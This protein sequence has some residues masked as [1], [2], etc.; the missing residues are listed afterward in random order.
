[1]M[2][3]LR[4]GIIAG[5]H[6]AIAAAQQIAS[7]I[8]STMRSAMQIQSPSR[9]MEG[10][11]EYIP[12][13]LAVGME[14]GI[15]DVQ[16]ATT[17]MAGAVTGDSFSKSMQTFNGPASAAPGQTI[18]GGGIT[19]APQITITGNASQGDVQNALQWSMAEF[20][21]MYERMMADDRRTAFA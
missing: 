9:V 11:G 19:F 2:Q 14:N 1:M 12:A 18:N 15:P 13:G 17:N 5:G 20:R 3:G 6:A 7:Q 10:I 21:R 4:N 8:E 16:A